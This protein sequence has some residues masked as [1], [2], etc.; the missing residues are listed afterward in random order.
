MDGGDRVRPIADGRPVIEN[1]CV[2]VTGLLVVLPD[3][4]LLLGTLFGDLFER[5]ANAFLFS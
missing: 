2:A 3:G 1:G 4:E 5:G